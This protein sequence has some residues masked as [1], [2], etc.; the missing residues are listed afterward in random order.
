M[1]NDLL[2]V[3][4]GRGCMILVRTTRLDFGKQMANELRIA[5]KQFG[6][7]QKFAIIVDLEE[8]KSGMTELLKKDFLNSSCNSEEWGWVNRLRLLHG[9][10]LTDI[11]EKIA[12]HLDQIRALEKDVQEATEEKKKQIERLR[13]SIDRLEKDKEFPQSYEDLNDL[14]CILIL[15]QRGK[16]GDTFPKSLRYYDLRMK[17][18]NTCESRAPVEQDLGR[19]FR[20]GPETPEYP[21]PT[22]LVGKKCHTQLL[23]YGKTRSQKQI[24]QLLPDNEKKMTPKGKKEFPESEEAALTFYRKHWKAGEEHYDFENVAVNE[25]RFLLVGRPQIGKTGAFLHLVELLWNRFGCKDLKLPDPVLVDS[26]DPGNSDP[27]PDPN[28]ITEMEQRKNML[29]YP[30]FDFMKATDFHDQPSSGKYGDP[31][32]ETLIEWYLHG[33]CPPDCGQIGHQHFQRE[34]HAEA[35]VLGRGSTAAAQQNSTL[36]AK[37]ADALASDGSAVGTNLRVNTSAAQKSLETSH[38]PHQRSREDEAGQHVPFTTFP[39][40]FANTPEQTSGVLHVPNDMLGH[41]ITPGA[42]G[43][44]GWWSIDGSACIRLTDRG[45]DKTCIPMP[46]FMPS[47]GRARC[48]NCKERRD[49]CSCGYLVSFCVCRHKRMCQIMQD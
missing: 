20:Y 28:P 44:H 45:S 9:K 37:G 2:N 17:Y 13:R 24:F 30:D 39:I 42:K 14:P 18:A 34:P 38:F 33:K 22:V 21:F 26:P 5:R 1:V 47:R 43:E 15:C 3:K 7:V 40:S 32:N 12:E 25:R 41:L 4:K 36:G 19:A 31:Q 29:L 16:M 23:G 48:K 11:E 49:S 6:L 8:Q 27:D 10:V 35:A 46:I